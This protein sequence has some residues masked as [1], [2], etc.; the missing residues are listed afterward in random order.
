MLCNNVGES[1][2]SSSSV[3]LFVFKLAYVKMH[4]H[5][6]GQT[7]CF[8]HLGY[9]SSDRSSPIDYVCWRGYC[10]NKKQA[11]YIF[12][13]MSLDNISTLPRSTFIQLC[14]HPHSRNH[15]RLS[16]TGVERTEGRVLQPFFTQ[17]L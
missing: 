12:P 7:H 6:F 4:M 5:G 13:V 17:S 14:N 16:N 11:T 15:T 9:P 1:Q 2:C 8:F 10:N 3:F